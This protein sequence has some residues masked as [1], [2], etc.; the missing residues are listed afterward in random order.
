MRDT[1]SNNETEKHIKCKSCA[2]K[3]L[4]LQ[5]RI[6][7]SRAVVILCISKSSITISL[8]TIHMLLYTLTHCLEVGSLRVPSS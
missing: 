6:W 5:L 2:D 4:L 3:L 8:E 7:V 1:Q